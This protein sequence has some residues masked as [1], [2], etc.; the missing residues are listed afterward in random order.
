MYELI[1]KKTFYQDMKNKEV[2]RKV[3]E[4]HNAI[5]KV[6]S[7]KMLYYCKFVIFFF[8]HNLCL[9][10]F[11]IKLCDLWYDTYKYA[12][13]RPASNDI[14]LENHRP[15]HVLD[16]NW[17]KFQEFIASYGFRKR[18]QFKSQNRNI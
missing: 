6:L 11:C 16:D 14:S 9:T 17:E 2:V 4:N 10:S 13:N 12:M 18:S 5:R 15:R 3:W 8:L 1:V 7:N